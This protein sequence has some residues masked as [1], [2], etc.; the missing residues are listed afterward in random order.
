MKRDGYDAIDAVNWSTLKLMGRSPAHYHAHLQRRVDDEDTDSLVLGRVTHTAVFEPDRLDVDYCLW[1]GRR[2]GDEYEA[3]CVD[4]E[5]KGQEVVLSKVMDRAMRIGLAV[6]SNEVC[7]NVIV[8]GEA[9]KTLRWSV[10]VPNWGNVACKGRLDFI[11]D[12]G[13]VDLKT[14]RDASPKRFGIS[15]AEYEYYAQAAFYRD[16]HLAV[17]GIDA[18]FWIIAVESAAPHVSQL[19]RVPD[20]MLDLGRERYM[21]LLARLM[22]CRER[23]QWPGYATEE[24]DVQLPPWA[25]PEFPDENDGGLDDL[26]FTERSN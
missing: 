8:R 19:Y 18:G 21:S 1:E 23:D 17:T 5:R 24:L 25:T 22:E 12:N 15:V 3:F 14:T 13:I 16:A 11:G 2:A 9:E 6:R 20:W 10:E 7:R 26:V 4:A